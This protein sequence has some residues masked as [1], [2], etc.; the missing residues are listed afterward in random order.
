MPPRFVSTT[1]V[2]LMVEAKQSRKKC[3]LSLCG[4]SNQSNTNK[5]LNLNSNERNAAL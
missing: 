4:M 1:F 2:F 3:D 5:H